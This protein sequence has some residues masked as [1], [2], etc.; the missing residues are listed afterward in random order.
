M[1]SSVVN[2]III[3]LVFVCIA[4]FAEAR[5]DSSNS[6]TNNFYVKE[7]SR[8][9]VIPASTTLLYQNDFNQ[10]NFHSPTRDQ[11]YR[12]QRHTYMFSPVG[13]NAISNAQLP[14]HFSFYDPTAKVSTADQLSVF[15][16]KFYDGAIDPPTLSPPNQ[17]IDEKDTIEAQDILSDSGFKPQMPSQNTMV[18][19]EPRLSI[20]GSKSFPSTSGALDTILQLQQKIV[21]N[22]VGQNPTPKTLNLPKIKAKPLLDLS[23]AV[24][25]NPESEQAFDSMLKQKRIKYIR[26]IKNKNK[27]RKLPGTN[28]SKT[29]I[30]QKVLSKFKVFRAV[31]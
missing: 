23:V 7:N 30:D 22:K 10:P 19:D 18:T 28:S 11:L 15:S 4:S 25:T 16:P 3:G 8:K 27:A 9:A 21:A 2:W 6:A 12:I 13:F 24:S 29:K 31:P 1:V 17:F 26:K 20:M 14:Y 5:I